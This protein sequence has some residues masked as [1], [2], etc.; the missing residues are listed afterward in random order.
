M[1]QL[2]FYCVN[3]VD[4]DANPAHTFP[5]SQTDWPLRAARAARGWSQSRA[6]EELASLASA[7]GVTVA[8]PLSLKTQ[9]SRWENQHALPEEHYRVLLQELY[10]STESELGLGE[11]GEPKVTAE[12]GADALRAQLSAA[13]AVDEST[14]ELLRGQ[15]RTTRA[16]DDRL[17]AAAV[18]N[19]AYA[20]LSYLEHALCHAI[21]PSNRRRL[22]RLVVDAATLAGRLA[23]DGARATEAWRHYE[24]AKVGAREAESPTLLGYSLV[25]QATVLADIGDPATALELVDQ[26]VTM[27]AADTPGPQRAWFSA[28][29]GEALAFSGAAGSAHDAYRSAEQQ[30]NELPVDVDISFAEIP[31]LEFDLSALRRH[32]GHARRLLRED[33][34]AIED[35]QRALHD[36]SGSSR[37]IAGIHVDLVHAHAAIGQPAEAARH[38]RSAREI[39][40]RIGSLRLTAQLDTEQLG[41]DLEPASPR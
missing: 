14:I 4:T 19:S 21:R 2:T 12:V 5:M 33:R 37:E 39:A 8:A 25:E 10:E 40:T 15:L 27:V 17:G 11:P 29:R 30:L 34:S 18:A 9:L 26:G 32:R 28:A 22:G 6:A 38:A 24:A 36:D 3:L 35:L 13:A 41:A 31:F 20:Q 16:L 23:L 1:M 7:R